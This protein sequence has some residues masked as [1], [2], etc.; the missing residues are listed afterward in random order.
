MQYSRTATAKA[1]GSDFAIC[2]PEFYHALNMVDVQDYV[3]AYFPSLRGLCSGVK[4]YGSILIT[5]RMVVKNT[6]LKSIICATVATISHQ[7][8]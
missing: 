5:G 1:P 4:L 3:N 2:E 6:Q 7:N 8:Q